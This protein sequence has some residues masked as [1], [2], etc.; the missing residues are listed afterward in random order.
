MRIK[1]TFCPMFT[2]LSLV[3]ST[4]RV[5]VGGPLT[6]AILRRDGC[7]KATETNAVSIVSARMARIARLTNATLRRVLCELLRERIPLIPCA[8][9]LRS[10]S[11]SM[12]VTSLM[13]GKRRLIRGSV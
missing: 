6:D 2:L 3:P 12:R 13:L 5:N 10:S 9:A 11:A 7:K 8:L 4:L 1:D